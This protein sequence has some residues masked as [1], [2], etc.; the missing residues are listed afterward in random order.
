MR[1]TSHCGP[2]IS[3]GRSLVL[4]L[5]LATLTAGALRARIDVSSLMSGAALAGSLAALI[6]AV[7]VRHHFKEVVVWR[8]LLKQT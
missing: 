1:T 7:T 4:A 5:A 8:A 3:R 2:A 6:L